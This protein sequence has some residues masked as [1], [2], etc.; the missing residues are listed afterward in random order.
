LKGVRRRAALA[1]NGTSALCG[2]NCQAISAGKGMS[3]IDTILSDAWPLVRR[4]ALYG[5]AGVI[6]TIVGYGVIFTLDVVL[7][8]DPHIANAAGYAVGVVCAFLLNRFLVFRSSESAARTGP[9][10]LAAAL[11]S[12][13]LNQL[14][15][16]GALSI[17]GH[18]P[19][20]HAVSQL[21][22]MA[23]Y[24]VATFLL[25]QLWVFRPAAARAS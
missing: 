22:G 14:V 24:T 1:Q 13:G 3:V 19:V 16:T 4:L 11:L 15:L 5:A 25:C 10:F 23:S 9:K 12:F 7:K 18:A 8:V 17:L 20:A 21:L 6:N 2:V